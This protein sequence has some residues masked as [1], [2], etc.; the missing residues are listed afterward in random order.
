[1]RVS[2]DIEE[3]EEN[4]NIRCEGKQLDRIESYEYLGVIISQD[5]TIEGEIRNRVSKASR[6][7]YQINTTLINKKELS[8]ETKLHL[9]KSVYLPTLTYGAESWPLQDK[10]KSKMTAAEMKYLRRV[11]GRTKRDRVRNTTTREELHLEPLVD[12]LQKRQLKWY[13]HVVRM[14]EER[15][16]RKVFEA[17]R[18]GKRGRGRPRLTWMDTIRREV[19]KRGKSMAEV[20]RLARDRIEFRK[21]IEDPTP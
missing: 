11:V 15:I 2:K 1:M 3:E 9:Y 13:G 14:G 6:V 5:G 4:I 21:W 18:E 19:E 8:K 17:R 16:P 20:K 7:Y 12:T 10:H